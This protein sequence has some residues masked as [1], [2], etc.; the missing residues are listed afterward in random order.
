MSGQDL[1]RRDWELFATTLKP[2]VSAAE[3]REMRWAF[4][5]GAMATIS[6]LLDAARLAEERFGPD[7]AAGAAAFDAVMD[8]LRAE[9]DRFELEVEATL[10]AR[11]D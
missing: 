8:G 3:R 5:L 2:G 1:L 11:P 7:D 9:L 4:M 10:H 6:R